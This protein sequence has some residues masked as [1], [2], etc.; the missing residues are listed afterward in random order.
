MAASDISV[1]VSA[2]VHSVNRGEHGERGKRKGERAK[3]LGAERMLWACP[4]RTDT[5]DKGEGARRCPEMTGKRKRREFT[6]EYKAEV[7]AL[8]R[9]TDK[10]VA[11]LAK[12]LD[13]TPSAVQ[14]WVTQAEVDAGKREGLTTTEREELAFLRRENRILREERDILKRA[15]AFFAKEI[16]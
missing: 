6:A 16:R 10:S 4:E 13:L 7:V 15:T 2:A 8:F 12:E 9:T 14:R 3:M 1:T 5:K 11:Q